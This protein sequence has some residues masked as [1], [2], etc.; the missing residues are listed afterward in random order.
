VVEPFTGEGIYYALATGELAARCIIEDRLPDYPRS[1]R[2]L[3]EGRLWINGLARLACKHPAVA[4]GLLRV[5]R[6]WPGALALLT[7]KVTRPSA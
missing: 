7:K 4:A 1:A 5:A 2:A 6:R 3:Y